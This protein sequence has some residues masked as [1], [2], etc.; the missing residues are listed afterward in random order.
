MAEAP[1]LQDL[2]KVDGAPKKTSSYPL[3]GG[4]SSLRG[5]FEKCTNRSTSGISRRTVL[6]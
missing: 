1:W 6:P 2:A 3:C 5:S 4:R